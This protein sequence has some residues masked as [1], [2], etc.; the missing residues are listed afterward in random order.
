VKNLQQ[1][2]H[3]TF[4]Y[5]IKPLPA[6]EEIRNIPLYLKGNFDLF[7]SDLVGQR[8]VWAEVKEGANIT[9]DQLKK[10]ELQLRQYL[11]AP[12]IFVFD[13]LPTWQRKRLIEKKV[14]FA[15]PFQQL[16]VPELL[17][18]IKDGHRKDLPFTPVS[19]HLKPPAQCLL[20]YHLQIQSLEEKLF[21]QIAELL[22]YSRMTVTR[23][24]KELAAF[25]LLEVIGNKEKFIRFPNNGRQLWDNALSYLASPVRETWLTEQL[26]TNE[27]F[28]ICGDTALAAYTMLAETNFNS[29]AIGKDAYRTLRTQSPYKGIKKNYGSY[30]LEIWHY[31]PVLLAPSSSEV[32]K[33]SLYLSMRHD[34]DERVQGAVTNLVNEMTWLQD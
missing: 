29:W 9:P 14:G 2:L 4:G 19:D 1:Y 3:E 13:S 28:R 21:H 32:D 11:H 27:Y 26:S 22:N 16:Y 23:A 17:L 33:L 15:E 30:K 8:V 18:Q 6:R 20:L 10:Q 34:P 24:V 12:I 5:F 25:K 7:A 31:D